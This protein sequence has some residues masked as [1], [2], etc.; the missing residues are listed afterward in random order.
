MWKLGECMRCRLIEEEVHLEWIERLPSLDEMPRETGEVWPLLT[1][2]TEANGDSKGTNERV[3]SFLGRSI[4]L[5]VN[6]MGLKYL[7]SLMRIRD[8]GWQKNS[9][10]GTEIYIWDPHH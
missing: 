5:V 1:V 7:N 4:G 2:E 6:P 3:L 10:P 8:P 9:D